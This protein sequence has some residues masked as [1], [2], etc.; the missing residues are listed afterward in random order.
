MAPEHKRRTVTP[1]PPVYVVSG[2]VGASG[3]PLV[4]ISKL[5]HHI[6]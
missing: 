3:E 5:A 4:W 1:P 2:G 6:S